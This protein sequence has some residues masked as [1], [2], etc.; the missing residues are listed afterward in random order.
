[1]IHKYIK[2]ISGTRSKKYVEK[3]KCPLRKF[4]WELRDFQWIFCLGPVPRLFKAALFWRVSHHSNCDKKHS[5]ESNSCHV[6]ETFTL[7]VDLISEIHELACVPTTKRKRYHSVINTCTVDGQHQLIIF[8]MERM[9][10]SCFNV[11]LL[12]TTLKFKTFSKL[13]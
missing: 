13:N 10:Y 12:A 6:I 2:S 3:I 5:C 1:M 9:D 11:F 4:S 7:R 8:Y